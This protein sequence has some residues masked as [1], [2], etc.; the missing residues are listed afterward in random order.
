MGSVWASSRGRWREFASVNVLFIL[1]SPRETSMCS[2]GRKGLLLECSTEVEIG[3]NCAFVMDT[4]TQ[5]PS[6]GRS[7][8]PRTQIHSTLPGLVG[9]QLFPKLIDKASRGLHILGGKQG[10]CRWRVS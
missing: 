6:V 1:A 5:L 2:Y 8:S 4:H 10:T 3:G 9:S 7:I